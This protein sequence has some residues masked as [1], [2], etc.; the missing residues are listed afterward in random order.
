VYQSDLRDGEVGFNLNGYILRPARVAG[1]NSPDTDEATTGVERDHITPV[2]MTGLGYQALPSKP[3]EPYAD[4]YRA[5]VLQKPADRASTVEYCV[6]AAVTS[7]LSTVEEGDSVLIEGTSAMAAPVAGNLPTSNPTLPSDPY[8]DGTATFRL[9]EPGGRDISQIY[10]LSVLS[11]DP[12]IGLVEIKQGETIG[13]DSTLSDLST[14]TVVINAATLAAL[15]GG[16]SVERGDVVV[17]VYYTLSPPT[18]WWTRN[19]QD[20]TR[21][22]WDG[23]NQRWSPLA[24]T[25]PRDMGGVV[26][27]K[28][29]K[30]APPPTRFAVDAL[31]PYPSSSDG[32]ALLRL[33]LYPDSISDPLKIQVKANSAVATGWDGGWD[34]T[35]DG[36]VGVTNGILRLNP[37]K[38]DDHAGK[39]LWYNPE[40]FPVEGDGDLGAVAGLP[41]TSNQGF[42]VLSPA[43]G[44]TERPF[45]RIGFRRHLTPRPVE[46]DADLPVPAAITTGQFYWS[47]TTGKIVLSEEDIEKATPGAARYELPYLGAH[48]YFDGVAMSQEPIPVKAPVAALDSGGK[49]IN[50]DTAGTGATT[51]LLGNLWIPRAVCL[52]PPG[53]SGVQWVPDGSGDTPDLSTVPVP[54]TRPVGNGL[55]RQIE[56]VG[57][58][59]L[60]SSNFA[61]EKLGVDEYDDDLPTISFKVA[62]NKAEVVEMAGVLQPTG[63]TDASRVECRRK[64][65]IDEPL[66]FRQCVTT[67]SVYVDEPRIYSRFAGPYT[68]GRVAIRFAINNQVHEWHSTTL[69]PSGVE[70]SYTAEEVQ[71]SIQADT[72]PALPADSVGVSR[73]RLFLQAPNLAS[74]NVEIGWNDPDQADLAAH[75]A[76]GFLPGW[77]VDNRSGQTQCRWLPDNGASMGVFRSPLNRNRRSSTPDIRSRDSFNDTVLID[78]IYANPFIRVNPPPLEDLPG[79]GPNS[80]FQTSIGL[81]NVDLENYATTLGVGVKYDWPNQRMVWSESGTTAPTK[82]AYPTARLQLDHISVFPETVSSDAMLNPGYGFY[83][84]EPD[85]TAYIEQTLGV[86]FLM[87]GQ[88]QPGQ[89]LLVEIEGG[90]AARGGAGTTGPALGVFLDAN[91]ADQDGLYAAVEPGYLLHILNGEAEGIYQI[92]AKEQVGGPGTNVVFTITPDMPLGI[93]STSTAQWR[94]Y[95]AELRSN[96]VV[97]D[98]LIADVQLVPTNHLPSEPFKIRLLSGIGTVGDTLEA[99]VADAVASDREVSVRF[100]VDPVSANMRSVTYLQRGTLLGAVAE[101]GLQVDPADPHFSES[102]TSGDAYFALRVGSQEYSTALGT[103]EMVAVVPGTVPAGTIQVVGFGAASNVGEIYIA[104][105]IVSAEGGSDVYYD[106][107]FLAPALIPAGTVEIDSS[108]G[109]LQIEAADALTYAGDTAYFVEQMITEGNLDVTTSPMNGSVLFNK[110]LR[111]GQIVEVSYYQA[112]SNGDKKLDADGNADEITEFLPL[113]VRLEEATLGSASNLFTYNPTGR[114]VST[115]VEPFVWVGVELMNFAGRENAVIDA[116]PSLIS[117]STAPQGEG[118]TVKINYGVLEAF[119][120]EQAYTVSTPPVYR[121]PFFLE[122]KQTAFTLET[123]RRTSFPTGHL[124]VLGS[125]P[126][127]IV[128]AAYLSASDTTVVTIWPPPQT[129]VGSRA[130]GRDARLL[131][132]DFPVAITIDPD[133][134]AISGG[135]SPGFLA[136]LNLAATPLLPVDKGQLSVGFYGDVRKWTRPN[137]LLEIDG[138]PY[139]ILT[140][141]LS[142]DGRNTKVQLATPIYTKQTATPAVGVSTRPVYGPAPMA[143]NPLNP[144][145]GD[146]DYSLFL[147]GSVD[148]DG[149]TLPGRELVEGTHYGL[150]KPGGAITFQRPTQ[151]PLKSGEILHLRYTRQREVSPAVADGALIYPLYKGGYLYMTTP[152]EENRLRGGALRAQYTYHSPD[153]F[154]FS[155][156]TL[157]EYL[158][159]VAIISA[160]KGGP[161]VGGGPVLAYPGSPDLTKKGTYGLRGGTADLGDQDRAAR[162]YVEFFNRVIVSFEQILEALDGRIIGDRDGKFRFFIGHDKRYA[163]PGW[164]DEITGLLNTRLIWREIIENW[165]PAAYESDDGFFI[166][167]DPIYNPITAEVPDSNPAMVPYRPGDTNGENLDPDLREFFINRQKSRIKNDMDDRVL[168]GTRRPKGLPFFLFPIFSAKGRYKDMWQD[169]FFSRLFPETTKHFSRL[170]PGLEAVVGAN[171]YTDPGFYSFGRMI[172]KPGPEPGEETDQVV[173]TRGTTIGT[174]ANPAL[175]EIPN[176]VDITAEDR[177]ARGRMWIY[178]PSGFSSANDTALGVTTNGLATIV[179]TPLPLSEFPIDQATGLPDVTQLLY[180]NGGAP[181]AGTLDSLDTGNIA[182]STPAFEAGQRLSYGQPNG[183]I[184]TLTDPDGF[185]VCVSTA[186]V[187]KGCVITLASCADPT[188]EI[189]GTSVFVVP[190]VTKLEEVV[191]EE[192]GYGD[193]IFA[194][195]STGTLASISGDPPTTEEMAAVIGALPDYRIQFDMK[196][197]R[198]RGEFVDASLPTPDDIF[199]FPFQEM[200]GQKPPAPLTCIEGSVDF[201]NTETEPAQLPCLLGESQDDSGDNQLPYMK[202]RS[203]LEV[204]GEVAAI[205]P[206]IF[207]DNTSETLPFQPD[208]L[209]SREEQDFLAVYPDE[210]LVTDGTIPLTSSYTTHSQNAATL[211]TGADVRPVEFAGAYTANSGEGDLRRYDLLFIETKQPSSA[212][213]G[214][215][216]WDGAT[217]ILTVGDVSRTLALAGGATSNRIEVPRFVTSVDDGN[218]HQYTLRSFAANVETVSGEQGVRVNENVVGLLRDTTFDFT[219][220]SGINLVGL[221]VLLNHPGPNFN[222]LVIRFYHTDPNHVGNPYIGAITLAGITPGVGQVIIRPA[223]GALTTYVLDPAGIGTGIVGGAIVCQLNNAATTPVTTLLGITPGTPYD[224]TL[225]IDTF[226]DVATFAV[227]NLV[228]GSGAGSTTCKVLRDRSTFREELG[229]NKAVARGFLPANGW[230]IPASYVSGQTAMETAFG[231][232]WVT[233]DGTPNLTVNNPA[234]I[235]GGDYLTFLERFGPDPLAI[236]AAGT[237]YVGAYNGSRGYIQAMSWEGTN[238]EALPSQVDNIV[239][240]AVPSSDLGTADV[241]LESTGTILDGD[242]S[243]VAASTGVGG[244][245]YEGNRN[246]IIDLDTTPA[247]GATENVEIGDIIVVDSAAGGGAYEGA[248]KAGTYLTRYAVASDGTY[249]TDPAISPFGEV[250]IQG[251]RQTA[252]PTSPVPVAQALTANSPTSDTGCLDL[253]FPYI[254]SAD[255]GTNTIV[256]GNVV[257]VAGTTTGHGFLASGRLY[258]V[259][260]EEYA[261]YSDDADGGGSPGWVL[262]KDSVW[263]KAILS[264]GAYDPETFT[265]VL[266]MNTSATAQDSAGGVSPTPPTKTDFYTA[267]VAGTVCSGMACLPVKQLGEHLAPNNVVGADTRWDGAT[268]DDTMGGWLGV[269]IHN[270]NPKMQEA[271]LAAG[272]TIVPWPVTTGGGVLPGLRNSVGVGSPVGHLIAVTPQ[273][274]DNTAFYDNPAEPVYGRVYDPALGISDGCGGVVSYFDLRNLGGSYSFLAPGMWYAMHFYATH[275]AVPAGL[276][277]Y[278]PDTTNVPTPENQCLLPGDRFTAGTD[279]DPTVADPTFYAL[280]GIFLEPSFPRPVLNNANV[281][282]KVVA[283]TYTMPSV[284]GIGLRDAADYGSPNTYEDVRFFVRRIRRWHNQQEAVVE[285]FKPLQ[286]I[287]ETRRG[288]LAS[289]TAFSRIVA[290]DTTPFGTATQLGDFTNPLVNINAGDVLRVLA[291]DGTLLA[292][293]EIQQVVSATSL[294]LRRPGLDPSVVTFTEAFEIYLEQPLVPQEQSNDQLLEMVTSEEIYRRTTDYPGASTAGGSVGETNEL[295]DTGMT[296]WEGAGVQADDYVVIDPA[297]VLYIESERGVRPF[298]DRSCVERGGPTYEARGPKGLDDNRG[299]YKVVDVDKN[300]AGDPAPGLLTVDGE[301]GFT[302]SGEPFGAATAEYVVLPTIH[303]SELTVSQEEDQQALRPTAAAVVSPAGLSFTDRAEG[304]VDSPAYKSIEPFA[305][306]IIRPNPIFSKDALELVLFMRER[307]LSWAEEIRLIQTKAGSYYI[308]QKEVHIED[309]GNATG[310]G[311]LGLLTNSE[312]ESLEGLVSIT[313]FANSDDCLSVLDRRVWILDFRLDADSYTDFAT[314]S[315]VQRPVLPDYIE[316]VLNLSDLFREQRFGWISFRGNREDGSIQTAKRALSS[317]NKRLA[318]ARRALARQRALNKS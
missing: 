278:L 117:L 183:R 290:V 172:T 258:L 142:E 79:Y 77:R 179:A 99:D 234:S 65:L 266:N 33:G 63:T 47:R 296:S 254:I 100:G 317:L 53:V 275:P 59:F 217:G 255:E 96:P 238:N 97:D 148:S 51:P 173:R 120:G 177:R 166:E 102:G 208:S 34:A 288:F 38:G 241:I 104:S 3:V 67:P 93:P 293:A 222:A 36:V 115:V 237:P 116:Q 308:F 260:K 270:M 75:A 113:I 18:F 292:T 71:A 72:V 253:T 178:L 205:L 68:L 231:L 283:N 215:A 127:Y 84:K 188:T 186:G 230:D 216:L 175:G 37:A 4:M 56:G 165:A 279:I 81:L 73:G 197:R 118:T 211:Y 42:P 149:N 138:Y 6:F 209:P 249:T 78:G 291:A 271:L 94:M 276:E 10:Y 111:E 267:A 294:K 203:E 300:S 144:L 89:S 210:I 162:V 28:T 31:L 156:E 273:P 194:I 201:N 88:A 155:V 206:V 299:F 314:N 153:S 301:C 145:V 123:D 85:E 8:Q 46:T 182:L 91:V 243:L 259:L 55:K 213:G 110:P 192:T 212:S 9:T 15:G 313:P 247:E 35:L 60:F 157:E 45:L 64:N 40:A 147:L 109:Q 198:R 202:S 152:S 95:E 21:F 114:T 264:L 180:N 86:D 108:T 11:G 163:P 7:S 19:D 250:A 107:L 122:E 193:T 185:G 220:V 298:G 61:F 30:L 252:D 154:F 196:V 302:Q 136:S 232:H 310:G 200:L 307:L 245:I 236:V 272:G 282:E 164:E 248:I 141:S 54:Q 134:A 29:Y 160:S 224:F 226:I 168:I 242:S 150:T 135:G 251:V 1:G 170:M 49:S 244:Y 167:A 257:R 281:V 289:Y 199:P 23:L 90:I 219:T 265:L 126:M 174:V 82:V 62:K 287:Y 83:V 74:G 16:F 184:Y 41:L 311:G 268:S 101:S 124:M 151:G 263:S 20:L 284:N 130:V 14:G 239:L 223:G 312:V 228:V 106:Q 286:Y 57:D 306:R 25:T 129:E 128:S 112:D 12:A 227:S 5:A 261:A 17:S 24:G 214:G 87:P 161:P 131:I 262:D 305:F 191:S 189:A 229:L 204:L 218:L 43:P 121:K 146:E 269:T 304:G 119:G 143:F 181:S 195:P 256:L 246:Y 277:V 159:E 92:T 187:Q 285:A 303:K 295:Q 316:D 280:G 2:V 318:K 22:G 158:G 221:T 139:I 27:D 225:D 105:D 171:G 133:G 58:N 233:I 176:I 140:S 70:T 207:D 66:Y 13:F 125:T 190:L 50:G 137:H 103:L 69:N 309:V 169:H 132:S 98:T 39:T 44:P 26:P 32:Y 48:L 235:N 80:H 274:K 315:L 76:L 297:G 240:S 52:P